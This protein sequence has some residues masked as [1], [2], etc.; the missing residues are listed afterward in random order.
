MKKIEGCTANRSADQRLPLAWSTHSRSRIHEHLA[1]GIRISQVSFSILCEES[2]TV[3]K[4][5]H[6][7]NSTACPGDVSG[8]PKRAEGMLLPLRRV[9]PFRTADTAGLIQCAHITLGCAGLKGRRRA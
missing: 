3:R 9:D 6:S 7:T 5:M 8:M 4:V 2:L 1:G